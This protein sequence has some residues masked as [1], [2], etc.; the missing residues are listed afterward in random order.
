MN[1]L[2][3]TAAVNVDPVCGMTVDEGGAAAR[4]QHG[5]KDYLF[6]SA[7]CLEKFKADPARYGA[8]SR[9]AALGFHINLNPVPA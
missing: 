7:Q 8:A 5:G 4:L 6:C 1:A 9:A 2:V 3:E